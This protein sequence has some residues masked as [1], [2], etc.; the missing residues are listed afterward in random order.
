MVHSILLDV[1]IIAERLSAR[2]AT[3]LAVRLLSW[4]GVVS[5]LRN[6]ICHTSR[7]QLKVCL[8]HKH[9][10]RLGM[11]L[12]H[13]V[14]CVHLRKFI[15]LSAVAVLAV[16]LSQCQNCKSCDRSEEERAR[17]LLARKWRRQCKCSLNAMKSTSRTMST[18]ESSSA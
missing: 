16:S 17:S 11:Q 13:P 5:C 7:M 6:A 4:R 1:G 12:K 2:L 18:R 14:C 3:N 9:P 10:S 15:V 8:V